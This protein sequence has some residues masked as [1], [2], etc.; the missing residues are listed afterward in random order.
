[1]EVCRDRHTICPRQ[2]EIQE[3]FEC[4]ILSIGVYV[5][6]S[7]VIYTLCFDVARGCTL[8]QINV[9]DLIKCF[10]F[11]RFGKGLICPHCSFAAWPECSRG[12]RIRCKLIFGCVP[13]NSMF[14]LWSY[15][16]FIA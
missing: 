16:K 12:S 1:M 10:L 14:Q 6:A 13:G 15:L 5:W 11:Y 7:S 2:R 4:S 3:E 8:L 9:F